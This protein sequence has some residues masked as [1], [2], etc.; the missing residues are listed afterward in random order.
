MTSG[1]D[2]VAWADQVL[3]RHARLS[4]HLTDGELR[5]AAVI[6]DAELYLT[7]LNPDDRDAERFL[8]HDEAMP[9]E[10]ARA[11]LATVRALERSTGPADHPSG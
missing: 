11:V 6:E 5:D 9:L 8:V 2:L 1:D 3:D 7:V 4:E 10:H